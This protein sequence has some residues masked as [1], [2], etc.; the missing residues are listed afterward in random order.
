MKTELM[1]SAMI[2]YVR[3]QYRNPENRYSADQWVSVMNCYVR[4]CNTEECAKLSD[5]RRSEAA[6][7]YTK[8]AIAVAEKA[9]SQA[10]STVRA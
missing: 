7:L 9:L 8:L 4:H 10:R 2:D 6:L 5:M 1:R 3:E